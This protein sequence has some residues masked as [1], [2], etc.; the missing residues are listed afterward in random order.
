MS[1][2]LQPEPSSPPSSSLA[3]PSSI[4]RRISFFHTLVRVAIFFQGHDGLAIIIVVFRSTGV[5][6]GMWQQVV[7]MTVVLS[8]VSCPT[9]L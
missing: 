4:Y 1:L 7:L 3:L 2:Q 6:V 5:V 9:S 8:P